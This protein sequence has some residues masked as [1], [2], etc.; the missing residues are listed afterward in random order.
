MS[1]QTILCVHNETGRAQK[2]CV[3]AGPDG[4]LLVGAL[5]W[6]S[7]DAAFQKA[8]REVYEVHRLES[9]CWDHLSS[10]HRDGYRAIFQA[11]LDTP[12]RFSVVYMPLVALPAA[13]RCAAIYRLYQRGLVPWLG[14]ASHARVLLP[15]DFDCLPCGGTGCRSLFV[16]GTSC[17]AARG[18][19]VSLAQAHLR[20]DDLSTVLWRTA[21]PRACFT[22]DMLGETDEDTRVAAVAR[23]LL[24]AVG[25]A[26]SAGTGSV[27][28]DELLGMLRSGG[29][30]KVH[31]DELHD[32]DGALTRRALERH[33]DTE[34]YNPDNLPEGERI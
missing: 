28:K 3:V 26:M 30:R 7:K 1:D 4:Q 2:G 29:K 24:D 11:F 6:P 17:P 15:S 32:G 23:L 31:V 19:E 12:A 25:Y 27:M 16:G 10:N 13:G 20:L 18:Q 22:V 5:S 34:L 33:A 21:S 8:M 9:L 14:A